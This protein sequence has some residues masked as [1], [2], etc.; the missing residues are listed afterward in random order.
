[1]K[2]IIQNYSENLV[3][4]AR[5]E[6]DCLLGDWLF[7]V[8]LDHQSIPESSCHKCINFRQKVIF[9][10]EKVLLAQELLIDKVKVRVGVGGIEPPVSSSRTKHDTDS[11]HP[12]L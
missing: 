1:M 12:E 10:R 3:V 2:E 7:H 9:A 6:L 4:I 8:E 11:L 5:M